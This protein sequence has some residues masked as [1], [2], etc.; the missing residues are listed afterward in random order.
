MPHLPSSPSV[1]ARRYGWV[2]YWLLHVGLAL[3][4]SRFPGYVPDRASVPYP[5]MEALL[6]CVPLFGFCAALQ[7]IIGPETFNRSWRR[8]AVASVLLLVLP[9]RVW[10]LMDM[11]GYY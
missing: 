11:P 8:L 6:T 4:A 1:F 3:D 10:N 5:W 2:A 7:A 9:A